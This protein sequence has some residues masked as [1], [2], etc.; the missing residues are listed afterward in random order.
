M[1][2][3]WNKTVSKLFL[4]GLNPKMSETFDLL[5]GLPASTGVSLL[6]SLPL[7]PL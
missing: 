2:L 7:Q 3:Q 1:V 4:T 6:D 5:L